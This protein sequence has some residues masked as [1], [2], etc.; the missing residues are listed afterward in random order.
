MACASSTMRAR[1]SSPR[2][3]PAAKLLRR[4]CGESPP[5]RRGG[6]RLNARGRRGAELLRE[7]AVGLPRIALRAR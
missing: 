4:E 2:K 5:L 3:L 6:G 7:I 1:H